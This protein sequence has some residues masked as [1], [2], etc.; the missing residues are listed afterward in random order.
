LLVPNSK[1]II[2][3]LNPSLSPYYILS[4]TLAS[5]NSD[6][7]NESILKPIAKNSTTLSAPSMSTRTQV[8]KHVVVFKPHKQKNATNPNLGVMP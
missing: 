6:L 1:L 5:I 7:G 8:S 2:A 4:K 3:N